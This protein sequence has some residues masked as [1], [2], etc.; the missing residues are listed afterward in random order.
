VRRDRY[1]EEIEDDVTQVTEDAWYGSVTV[2]DE[3]EPVATKESNL[4]KI[5]AAKALLGDAS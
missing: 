1:G 2:A 4:A 5:V 3:D